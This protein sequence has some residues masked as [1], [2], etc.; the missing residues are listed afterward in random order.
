MPEALQAVSNQFRL[1]IADSYE[2]P[3]RQASA[4]DFSDLKLSPD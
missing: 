3:A 4:S 1:V 2:V